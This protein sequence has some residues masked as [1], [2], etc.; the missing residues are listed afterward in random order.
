VAWR[1]DG[2][3]PWALRGSAWIRDRIRA[4]ETEGES[5]A[6]SRKRHEARR[7][8]VDEPSTVE[9]KS[10]GGGFLFSLD[11]IQ[12]PPR[13]RPGSWKRER[14]ARRRFRFL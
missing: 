2:A 3:D 7:A 12:N 1:R 13:T 14:E 5:F 11:E 9:N 10:G 8:V 4:R 6:T